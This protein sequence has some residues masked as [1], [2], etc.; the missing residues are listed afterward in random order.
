M[1]AQ[2]LNAFQNGMSCSG[3]TNGL[4]ENAFLVHVLSGGQ[5]ETVQP[6]GEVL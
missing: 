4:R 5:T 2:L 3:N 1:F 6:K